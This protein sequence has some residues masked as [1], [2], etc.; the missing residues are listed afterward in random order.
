MEEQKSVERKPSEIIE[1]Y[2]SRWREYD[3]HRKKMEEAWGDLQLMRK[4]V[5][6]IAETLDMWAF[7]DSSSTLLIHTGVVSSIGKITVHS[8]IGVDKIEEESI[9]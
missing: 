5:V 4:D 3:G 1:A 9:K 2:L 8:S 7:H 6:R